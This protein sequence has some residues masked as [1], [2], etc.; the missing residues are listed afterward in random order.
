MEYDRAL[1]RVYERI[2]EDL[3]CSPS[4]MILASQRSSSTSAAVTVASPPISSS[5]RRSHRRRVNR[6]NQEQSR[7]DET[8]VEPSD[9]GDGISRELSPSDH[10]E[11]EQNGDGLTNT[12]NQHQT[13]R[14]PAQEDTSLIT[15]TSNNTSLTNRNRQRRIRR[16]RRRHRREGRRMANTQQL[17]ANRMMTSRPQQIQPLPFFLPIWLSLKI[18]TMISRLSNNSLTRNNNR[19][20]P[21]PI[22]NAHSGVFDTIMRYVRNILLRD[23]GGIHQRVPSTP[24]AYRSLVV[25]ISP[26]N[27]HDSDVDTE[28][29]DVGRIGEEEMLRMPS[30]SIEENESPSSPRGG[31]RRRAASNSSAESSVRSGWRPSG[32]PSSTSTTSSNS[33][34]QGS[35]RGNRSATVAP[36]ITI[37]SSPLQNQSVAT[38]SLQPR[39]THSPTTSLSYTSS[40]SGD[41]SSGSNSV[42]TYSRR[43]TQVTTN[44][45]TTSLAQRAIQMQLRQSERLQ[46]FSSSRQGRAR[47]IERDGSDSDSDD[48]SARDNSSD[49]DDS[50][51]DA[52]SSDSSSSIHT[53]D[54]GPSSNG[55]CNQLNVY[56][57]MRLSFF[58]GCL[59]L[60]VLFSLHVTYVGPYAFRREGK[61]MVP[62]A[63]RRALLSGLNRLQTTGGNTL[64][65]LLDTDKDDNEDQF[66]AN[67]IASA[68]STRSVKDR[69]GYFAMFG[70]GGT[71]DGKRRS[72]LES[73]LFDD[74]YLNNV[75]DDFGYYYDDDPWV[76]EGERKLPESSSSV[77]LLQP[78]LLGKDEILQ[79]KILYGGKCSGKCSRVRTVQCPE[80][81]NNTES[82]GE[83]EVGNKITSLQQLADGQVNIDN[84]IM[85]RFRLRGHQRRSK[86]IQQ[87]DEYRSST[88]SDE[89]ADDLIEVNHEDM[90]NDETNSRR[91]LDSVNINVTTK[92][93]EEDE[94]SSSSFWEEPHYRYAI[95]DALLYLDE[96]SAYLHNIT[97]VNV[98]VTERCLSSGSDDGN[99]SMLETIG[100]FLS[101]IYGMDSIIINQLMYGVRS[102]DG[103]FQ[104]GHVQSMETKERWGWRKEQLDAYENGSFVELVLKKIGKL[105]VFIIFRV[106]C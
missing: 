28:D 1:Y 74:T 44:T 94:L 31:L 40:S 79:I 27:Q 56:R 85:G 15:G 16:N 73:D 80:A 64:R 63:L 99:L 87:V 102:P 91:R 72:L 11:E 32:S 60:F 67:C 95:D 30:L 38:T 106:Q 98:T 48:A 54:D 101:Q 66:L 7:S 92:K 65:H 71:S 104:S 17:F 70:D 6:H 20:E 21:I 53:H 88:S 25:S 78:P 36:P 26:V 18:D 46:S 51:E 14:V 43:E 90:A 23:G 37:P 62:K 57:I 100:E 77:Q 50:N 103:S 42:S 49:E 83:G 2:M 35:P 81:T 52:E 12:T 41:D 34:P 39:A 10:D 29:V 69:G 105:I 97:I 58:V 59:H 8:D 9:D 89:V 55:G 61:G 22:D 76:P 47:A 96:K 3:N 82:E 45:A 93:V 68:L 84:E 33:S 86:W 19:M 5:S 24:T 75:T 4:P 13:D